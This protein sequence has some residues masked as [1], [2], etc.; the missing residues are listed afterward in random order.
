MWFL[1][2]ITWLLAG[3]VRGA[4]ILEFLSFPDGYS[5]YELRA[6]SGDG[7]TLA[8]W[9]G[10]SSDGG[11]IGWIWSSSDGF[12]F[13]EEGNTLVSGISRDGSVAV[14][15][16]HSERGTEAFRWT[17]SG[18]VEWL[19]DLPARFPFM[20]DTFWSNGYSISGDGNVIHGESLASGAYTAY[21]WTAGEG[22]VALSGYHWGTGIWGL[23]G[24]GMVAVGS[25]YSD[26]RQPTGVRWDVGAGWT[27][28][29]PNFQPQ[30][31][32]GDG[33]TVVGKAYLDYDGWVHTLGGIV[34]Q[35]GVL[36]YIGASLGESGYAIATSVS[37]DG[38]VVSGEGLFN[39]A[40]QP[41]VW[42]EAS[43]MRSISSVLESAGM[44]LGGWQ[45]YGGSF[46]SEDGRSFAGTAISADGMAVW[47]ATVPEPR[48]L[49]LSVLYGVTIV[50]TWRRRR[51]R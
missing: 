28:Y 48:G 43:G 19:G 9:G 17:R 44:D 38:S 2:G 42:S 4:G 1:A 50:A 22:M 34:G 15:Q 7:S 39:D 25:D 12:T 6:F 33:T 27:D 29:G 14:G 10:R 46:V 21:R 36:H 35:D 45:L 5:P 31:V 47:V 37:A 40:Y 49:L 16:G 3:D 26:S 24:D 18:G 11:E 30:A 20:N 13:I 8:G 23:S 41:F 51:N 32:S